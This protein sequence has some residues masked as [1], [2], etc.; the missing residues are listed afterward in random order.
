MFQDLQHGQEVC[1]VAQESEG[2]A[3]EGDEGARGHSPKGISTQGDSGSIR[4]HRPKGTQG[5]ILGAHDN[6]DESNI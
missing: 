1:R 4:G 6:D 2:V 5:D 3:L